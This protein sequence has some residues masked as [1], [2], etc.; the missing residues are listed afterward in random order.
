MKTWQAYGV[1]VL[2]SVAWAT[3]IWFIVSP[4]LD[5]P[6]GFES[7]L[8]IVSVPFMLAIL[9]RMLRREESH[10]DDR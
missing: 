7:V 10:Q 3:F 2:A 1:A 6:S 5:L 4:W 9:T 8:V